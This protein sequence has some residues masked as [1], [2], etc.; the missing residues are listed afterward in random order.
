MKFKN[1]ERLVLVHDKLVEMVKEEEGD[2]PDWSW[3]SLG[4]RQLGYAIDDEL[5]DIEEDL[6][7]EAF[8]D[9]VVAT[10]EADSEEPAP[11]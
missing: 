10:T 8:L 7:V 11:V 5:Q 6:K 3:L 4:V 1:L 2:S 9:D